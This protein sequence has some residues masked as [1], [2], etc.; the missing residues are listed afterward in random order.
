MKEKKHVPAQDRGRRRLAL[1]EMQD[2]QYPFPDSDVS[3]IFDHFLALELI[4][5]LEM[6]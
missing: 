3:K 4:E 5:L 1:Q 6:K 2:K